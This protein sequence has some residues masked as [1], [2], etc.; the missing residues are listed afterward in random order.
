MDES[1]EKREEILKSYVE[2]EEGVTAKQVG[3]P[4]TEVKNVINF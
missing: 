2:N 3:A 4:L 1:L